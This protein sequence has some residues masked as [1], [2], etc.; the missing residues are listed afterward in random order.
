MSDDL[1]V[2]VEP[3]VMKIRRIEIGIAQGGGFEQATRTHVMLPMIDKG[4]RRLM[5]ARATQTR[6][7]RKRAIEELLAVLLGTRH[8]TCQV[9][10]G[11]EARVGHKVDIVDIGYERIQC[12]RGRLSACEFVDDHVTYK[13][14]QGISSAIV[15]VRS[16]QMRAPQTGDRQRIQH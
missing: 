5:T 9:T 3:P 13:I 2:G 1:L 6:V 10:A 15:A 12:F 4:L 7:M 16:Q 11:A 14:S 8:G